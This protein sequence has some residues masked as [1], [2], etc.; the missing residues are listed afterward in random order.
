MPETHLRHCLANLSVEP[1]ANC[2][3]LK[4]VPPAEPS[5]QSPCRKGKVRRESGLCWD[6]L[7]SFP[8]LFKDFSFIFHEKVKEV[9]TAGV[10]R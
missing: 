3:M 4:S 6:T 2:F 9:R 5:L 8:S 1:S 10:R 7:C